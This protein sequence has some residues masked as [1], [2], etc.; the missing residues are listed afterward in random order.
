ML[1][2]V[3]AGVGVKIG[4][5]VGIIWLTT[6]GVAVGT[7]VLMIVAPVFVLS[8]PGPMPVKSTKS[9]QIRIRKRHAKLPVAILAFILH[10]LNPS[11]R[12]LYCQFCS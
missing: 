1:V 4:V 2:G 6:E 11:L 9:T 3:R 7:W 5:A 12:D 10:A 8:L